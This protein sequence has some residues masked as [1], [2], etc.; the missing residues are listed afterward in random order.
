M[1]GGDPEQVA[2]WMLG[3]IRQYGRLD[4]WWAV[5]E[6]ESRFGGEFVYANEHGRLEIATTVLSA[7]YRLSE[8]RSCG[9]RMV[10]GGE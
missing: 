8:A 1:N 10:R 5:Q 6:I 9:I 3:E 4:Q 7:F 2:R